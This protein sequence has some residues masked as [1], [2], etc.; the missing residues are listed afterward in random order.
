MIL[1]FC[2]VKLVVNLDII[3]RV[4]HR[5]GDYQSAANAYS[6]AISKDAAMV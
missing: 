5:A 1:K 4:D 3:L 6:D 2:F